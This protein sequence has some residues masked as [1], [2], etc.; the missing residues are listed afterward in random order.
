MGRLAVASDS[1]GP[2]RS[3]V[4][5][6]TRI[7]FLDGNGSMKKYRVYSYIPHHASREM[8]RIRKF[9][10][11]SPINTFTDSDPVSALVLA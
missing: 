9:T 11:R 1:I 10:R 6:R 8:K 3:E 7:N 5:P 4:S 2:Y